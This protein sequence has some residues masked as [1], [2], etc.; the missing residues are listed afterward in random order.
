MIEGLAFDEPHPHVGQYGLA[1]V[2]QL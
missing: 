2:K 1:E